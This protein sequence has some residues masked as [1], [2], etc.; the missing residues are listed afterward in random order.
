MMGQRGSVQTNNQSSRQKVTK[1]Q[2]LW[3]STHNY[4]P[5]K[6]MGFNVCFTLWWLWGCFGPTILQLGKCFAL[7]FFFYPNANHLGFQ[8]LYIN[9]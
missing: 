6:M 8:Y 7:L 1:T 4:H 3:G 5:V 2:R 9:F